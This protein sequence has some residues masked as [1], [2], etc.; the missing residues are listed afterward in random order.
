MSAGNFVHQVLVGSWT[1]LPPSHSLWVK[2]PSFLFCG[3]RYFTPE[4]D[5]HQRYSANAQAGRKTDLWSCWPVLLMAGGLLWMMY[6]WGVKDYALYSCTSEYLTSREMSFEHILREILLSFLLWLTGQ[7]MYRY[8]CEPRASVVDH[9][10]RALT[11]LANT[12]WAGMILGTF[13]V[14]LL[15][16]ATERETS[17]R[18]DALFLFFYFFQWASVFFLVAPFLSAMVTT[19]ENK[20]LET[21]WFIIVMCGV[22]CSVARVLNDVTCSQDDYN[23][24]K[25]SVAVLRLDQLQADFIA[26]TS[27]AFIRF[28]HTHAVAL[29]FSIFLAEGR[30]H[31][32]AQEPDCFMIAELFWPPHKT[33]KMWIFVIAM[34]FFMFGYFMF[35]DALSDQYV[36]LEANLVIEDCRYAHLSVAPLAHFCLNITCFIMVVFVYCNNRKRRSMASYH[37]QVI[38][39]AGLFGLLYHT[40]AAGLVLQELKTRNVEWRGTM[41]AYM[42]IGADVIGYLSFVVVS[43]DVFSG[44]IIFSELGKQCLFFFALSFWVFADGVV[45]EASTFL[46]EVWRACTA[47]DQST[48]AERLWSFAGQAALAE[49]GLFLMMG[50]SVHTIRKVV[51]VLGFAHMEPLPNEFK[52]A[53]DSQSFEILPRPLDGTSTRSRLGDWSTF[54]KRASSVQH[55]AIEPMRTMSIARSEQSIPVDQSKRSLGLGAWSSRGLQDLATPAVDPGV[56]S[57]PGVAEGIM[58]M[59]IREELGPYSRIGELE[60]RRFAVLC[61][62]HGSREDWS[63]EYRQLCARHFWNPSG[64]PDLKQ[65]RLFLIDPADN[66]YQ[67]SPYLVELFLEVKQQL[68][69]APPASEK[70]ASSPQV[71]RA[72]PH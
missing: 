37:A 45:I 40:Y 62:F 5:L 21:F 24:L 1:E 13:C 14:Q 68:W 29:I 57:R 35:F 42:M 55:A 43:A 19:T 8:I 60:M 3:M 30:W 23:N 69:P 20:V 33:H 28:T 32:N 25:N 53:A 15:I 58:Q 41:F 65:F 31:G 46:P 36:N 66:R 47:N 17:T 10:F 56:L 51:E 52:E 27:Y 48:D 70:K 18:S 6:W 50:W 44:R 38:V 71:R 12:F 59:C 67:I 22:L 2:L 49:T 63:K 26:T 54:L 39:F 64:G 61:G 9:T 11:T 4:D 7:L 16:S 34:V 72:R